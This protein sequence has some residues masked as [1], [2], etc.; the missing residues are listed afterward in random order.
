MDRARQGVPRDR[1]DEPVEVL[2]AKYLDYCSARVTD[3][4]LRLSPDEMYV[5]AQ[6]AARASGWSE[7][8]SLTYG[9]IVAL[10]T[11][12]ISRRIDLPSFD[13]WCEAYRAEPA[14]FEEEILGLWEDE[15][16]P[17]SDG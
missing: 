11:Q 15:V 10:A 14:R 8:E 12:R 3:A 16:E 13:E 2:R 9:D 5:F 7:D 1:G 4:L 17:A 6:E